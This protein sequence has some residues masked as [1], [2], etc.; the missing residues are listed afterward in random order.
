MKKMVSLFLAFAM[1]VPLCIPAFA[2][3]DNAQSNSTTM[4]IDQ[5]ESRYVGANPSTDTSV[6]RL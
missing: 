2:V 4:T 5:F 3:G 1:S 6:S